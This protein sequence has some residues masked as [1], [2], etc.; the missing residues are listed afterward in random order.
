MTIGEHLLRTESKSSAHLKLQP[1]CETWIGKWYF[2]PSIWAKLKTQDTSQVYLCQ[3][4][5][6]EILCSNFCLKE[7]LN[8]SIFTSNYPLKK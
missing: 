3:D 6:I 2:F 7:R 1:E 5:R 4:T 8:D